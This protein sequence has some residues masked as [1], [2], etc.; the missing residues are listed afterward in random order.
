[1]CLS[2]LQPTYSFLATE[3]AQ[4]LYSAH[5]LETANENQIWIVIELFIHIDIY[6]AKCNLGLHLFF[7]TLC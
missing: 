3:D 5:I 4:Y 2:C 6:F 1:M 7:L